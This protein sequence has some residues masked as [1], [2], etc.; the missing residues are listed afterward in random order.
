MPK[1]EVRGSSRRVDAACGALAIS[2]SLLRRDVR[3]GH[4]MKNG[5]YSIHV[6]LQDG[7]AGKGSG[8][9]VFRDGRILGGDAH[10]F[11]TGSHKGEGEA[12]QG[13][14]PCRPPDS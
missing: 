12:V 1:R 10:P 11:C 2:A 9:V 6:S 7:R 3:T 5:L 4:V 13:V 8:V 14:V